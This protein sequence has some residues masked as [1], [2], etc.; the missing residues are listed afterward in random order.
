MICDA[1]CSAIFDL[2]LDSSSLMTTGIT[3]WLE[4][5]KTLDLLMVVSLGTFITITQCD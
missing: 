1:H 5:T 4:F 3:L 2:V